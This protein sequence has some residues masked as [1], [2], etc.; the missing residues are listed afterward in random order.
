MTATRHFS[1]ARAWLYSSQALGR[2]A[3]MSWSLYNQLVLLVIIISSIHTFLHALKHRDWSSSFAE[4]SATLRVQA[5]M[6]G[7]AT[8]Q[9]TTLCSTPAAMPSERVRRLTSGKDA[10][11]AIR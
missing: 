1:I 9:H 3:A 5:G 6:A 10:A 8:A 4:L 7:L 11:A 2:P